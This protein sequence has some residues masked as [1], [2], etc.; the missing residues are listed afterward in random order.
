[1]SSTRT[2]LKEQFYKAVDQL[3]KATTA[4]L[5]KAGSA[6]VTHGTNAV[7][8]LT[9]MDQKHVA[10]YRAKLASKITTKLNVDNSYSQVADYT[11]FGAQVGTGAAMAN[12]LRWNLLE[13]AKYFLYSSAYSNAHIEQDAN[14]QNIWSTAI[15]TVLVGAAVGLAIGLVKEPKV[16]NAEKAP[17]QNTAPT[18]KK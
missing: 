18:F 14:D 12:L 6:V 8:Y 7:N 1:M 2:M 9:S 11:L 17:E 15:K 3:H 10:H 5:A 13:M 16:D 4:P